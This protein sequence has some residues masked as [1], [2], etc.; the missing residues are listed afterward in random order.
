MSRR[1]IL[2]L[3]A[4]AASAALAGCADPVTAPNRPTLAPRAASAPGASVA[5]CRGGWVS[6]TGR[7]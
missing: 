6:S 2:V 3:A 4:V 7:C 5:A 1:S